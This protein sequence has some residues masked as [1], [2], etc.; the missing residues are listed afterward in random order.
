[1]SEKTADKCPICGEE[2]KNVRA[3]IKAIHRGSYEYKKIKAKESDSG[4]MTEAD[5]MTWDRL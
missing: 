5:Y 3:H 4:R 2:K 1:M